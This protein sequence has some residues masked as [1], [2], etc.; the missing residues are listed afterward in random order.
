MEMD[1]KMKRKQTS[2]PRLAELRLL[3][4]NHIDLN[5]GGF[6]LAAFRVWKQQAENI[7]Q[8]EDKKYLNQILE[9]LRKADKFRSRTEKQKLNSPFSV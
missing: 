8:R 4:V 3:I 9:E 1:G 5:L 2:D 6:H 7:C